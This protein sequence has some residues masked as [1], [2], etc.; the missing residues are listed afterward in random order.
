VG[1]PSLVGDTLSARSIFWPRASGSE[2]PQRPGVQPFVFASA[3][4]ASPR[5]K[6]SGERNPLQAS[7]KKMR[8]SHSAAH[9]PNGSRLSRAVDRDH[10]WGCEQAGQRSSTV[11]WTGIASK[12]SN[13]ISAPVGSTAPVSGQWMTISKVLSANEC[14]GTPTSGAKTSITGS[15]FSAMSVRNRPSDTPFVSSQR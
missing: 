7:A 3:G 14:M 9:R 15:R 6:A 8:Q 5:E 2:L 10:E 12:S 4:G 11:D 13:L 1:R